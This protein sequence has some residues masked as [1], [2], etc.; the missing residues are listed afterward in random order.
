MQEKFVFFSRFW[1]AGL[2]L[3]IISIPG[4]LVDRLQIEPSVISS[5][6]LL[7]V[8]V[9]VERLLMCG[10]FWSLTYLMWKT[11]DVEDAGSSH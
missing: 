7:L 6:P 1:L 9:H 3:L 11:A 10:M 8:G 4:L 5:N 2:G